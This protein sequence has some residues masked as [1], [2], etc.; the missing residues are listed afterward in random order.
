MVLIFCIVITDDFLDDNFH[1]LG[2]RWFWNWYKYDL[3]TASLDVETIFP[4]MASCNFKTGGMAGVPDLSNLLCVLAPN[5]LSE[6]IFIFLWFWYHILFII[7]GV[8]LVFVI[9]MLF[10]ARSVRKLY[11][12][13]YFCMRIEDLKDGGHYSSSQEKVEYRLYISY[14]I[15]I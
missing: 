7:I 10:K 14:Y 2:S 3:K 12:K 1:K 13:R 5:A 11:V 6:K 15:K 8:N 4:R 9:G